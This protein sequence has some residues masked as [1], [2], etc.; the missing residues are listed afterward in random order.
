[1]VIEVARANQLDVM[2]YF[3]CIECP[4]NPYHL[5]YC[6]DENKIGIKNI[7]ENNYAFPA[8]GENSLRRKMFELLSKSKIPQLTLIAPSA[9]ISATSKIG[10]STLI[11]PNAV[12]NSQT[13]V[14]DACIINTGAILEHE[15]KIGSYTHIAPGAVLAGNVYVGENTFIGANAVIKQG[16]RIT[17]NVVIGA[18]SVVLNDIKEKGIW[19][20]NPARMIKSYEG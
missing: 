2:G 15:C 3:D 8:V 19:V 5:S 4:V 1:M 13:K 14:G 16:I 20:G 17:N 10:T 18:G 7:V 11:N 9:H 6:G 12:L